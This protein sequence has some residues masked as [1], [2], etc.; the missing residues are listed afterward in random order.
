MA[1]TSKRTQNTYDPETKTYTTR[2]RIVETHTSTTTVVMTYVFGFLAGVWW[3]K[4]SNNQ[5]DPTD[6]DN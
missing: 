3:L 6:Q 1:K 2:E 5:N 4:K